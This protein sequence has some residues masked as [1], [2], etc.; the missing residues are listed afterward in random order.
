MK[1]IYSDQVFVVRL[2]LPQQIAKMGRRSPVRQ[3]MCWEIF[4]FDF[5][6]HEQ[7]ATGVSSK[8]QK[9]KLFYKNLMIQ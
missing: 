6:I 1:K 4:L 9:S 7:R 8:L 3:E 2:K 5:C